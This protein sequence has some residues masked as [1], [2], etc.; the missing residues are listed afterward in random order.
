MLYNILIEVGVPTRPV[1]LIKMCK[2]RMGKN[3][4]EAIFIKNG[5]KGG[6][7]LP[8]SLLNSALKYTYSNR[9]IQENQVELKLNWTN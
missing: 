8:S 7:A 4:F 2:V 9:K 5:L 6:D 3:F 1:Q